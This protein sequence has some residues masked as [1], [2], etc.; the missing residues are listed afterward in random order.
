[1]LSKTYFCSYRMEL[2]II[3]VLILVNGVFSMS[4]IA[5]VSARKFKLQAK[6]RKGNK[7]AK[8]ALSLANKPNRFLSAVQ[9]GITLIGILLGVFSSDDMQAS[10]REW[11]ST[12]PALAEY[13]RTLSVIIIVFIVTFLTIV[14]GEL[15]PK[16][17]GL[18]F[19]EKI[20]MFMAAPMNIIS[21]ITAPFIWLLTT[22][23]RF[24]LWLLRIKHDTKGMVTEEE[25]KAMVDE[26]AEYGDV[27]DI[28][29]RIVDR[30]FSL[31][32]RRISELMTHRTNVVWLDIN[33]EG[34]QMRQ[35]INDN[36]HSFYPIGDG[37]LDKLMGVVSLKDL[38]GANA[39]HTVPDLKKYMLQPLILHEHTPPYKALEAYKESKVH[40][41][42]VVDEY[43]AILGVVTMD[44]MLDA[45]VGDVSE[46]DQ[47]EYSITELEDGTWLADAQ[48]PYFELLHYFNIDEEDSKYE[49]NTIAGLIL[50]KSKKIPEVGETILWYNFELRIVDKDGLRIDKVQIKKLEPEEEEVDEWGT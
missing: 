39:G 20:A 32:D 30:A 22:T 50:E 49:F 11:L 25:I 40:F 45:L 36:I 8:R 29:H 1:M 4:E 3:I 27:Q 44:D 38:F 42:I 17:I 46:D 48:Y 31:G 7:S 24:F 14:F 19:P 5:L 16:R 15:L 6:A 33:E 26:S 10:L 12:I 47:G 21:I 18:I 23:N 34:T 35:R 13:A 2:I 28:E 43:G 9:I 41:A 37:S